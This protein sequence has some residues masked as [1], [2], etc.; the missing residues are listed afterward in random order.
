MENFS[1]EFV[2]YAEK[3]EVRSRLGAEIYQV[4]K[5]CRTW[6]LPMEA[7][8][9]R[10]IKI[11]GM[12]KQDGQTYN[13]R[14][15]LRYPEARKACETVGKKV[16]QNFIGG[17][18]GEYFAVSPKPGSYGATVS[19]A[20]CVKNIIDHYFE[21]ESQTNFKAETMP[22]FKQKPV[23]GTSVMKTSWTREEKNIKR[24]GKQKKVVVKDCPTVRTIDM[25]KW[26]GFPWNKSRAEDLTHTFEGFSETKQYVDSMKAQGKY[27][28]EFDS[29]LNTKWGAQLEHQKIMQWQLPDPEINKDHGQ[30]LYNLVEVYFTGQVEPEGEY[31][32]LMAHMSESGEIA[33]I[34]DNPFEHGEHPYIVDKHSENIV[35]M[36][37]G[38]GVI[39]VVESLANELNDVGNQAMDAR[40]FSLNPIFL[41]DPN[42][43]RNHESLTVRPQAKWLCDPNSIKVITPPDISQSAFQ[44]FNLIKGEII[45]A[46]ESS[47]N[48]PLQM[49][50]QS[51]TSAR[52]QAMMVEMNSELSETMAH[53]AMAMVRILKL[54]HANICQYMPNDM[55]IKITRKD[56]G[57]MLYRRVS[58]KDILGDYDF[59]FKASDDTALDRVAINQMIN[60]LKVAPAIGV[61]LN[62]DNIFRRLLRDGFGFEDWGEFL[63]SDTLQPVM[64]Q[65]IENELLQIG[66]IVPIHPQD[67]DEE[68]IQEIQSKFGD[69]SSISNKKIQKTVQDHLQRHMIGLQL[70]QQIMLDQAR[71]Q[72]MQQQQAAQGG[73]QPGGPQM[74]G[75]TGAEAMPQGTSESS[76]EQGIANG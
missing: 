73:Q 27:R 56:A 16:Y 5:S 55:I 21:S 61:K 67:N 17:N 39:E 72:M 28:K 23:I 8:W 26:Y 65:E 2:N 20:E 24:R 7:S 42:G 29:G 6:R 51:R 63:Q 32:S 75:K 13:G 22:N 25:F 71:M 60:L 10:Y 30:S 34:T 44:S 38:M 46:A 15:D 43:V 48:M 19:D 18:N 9:V 62:Y 3:E 49:R 41:I 53:S 52:D 59:M 50:G 57:S 11:W 66:K 33:M 4:Y 64:E 45:E 47:P 36:I 76:M 31:K 40:T 14:A 54:T 37:Y 58:A 12:K 70:K 74:P 68:H 1:E 69:P 35:P